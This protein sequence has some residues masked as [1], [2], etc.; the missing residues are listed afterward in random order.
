MCFTQHKK[1]CFK[2]KKVMPNGKMYYICI[3]I[4][5]Y[6]QNI[7]TAQLSSMSL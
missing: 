4:N 7:K 5:S 3:K 1:H 6:G 2:T